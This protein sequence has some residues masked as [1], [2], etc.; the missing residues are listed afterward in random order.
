MNISFLGAAHEVTGS[1]HCLKACGKT[2]LIDFGMRQGED[3]ND[4]EEL[5]LPISPTKVD[6]VLL[7]HAHIDHSGYLPLLTKY[8]FKG[9]IYATGATTDLCNIMLRDSAHIQEFETEW[10]NRKGKRAGRP[11][12]EPIYDMQDAEEVL[13]HFVPCEYDKTVNICDGIDVTF[14][15]AGHLLGSAS[16]SVEINE[17][18]LERTVVF[19]GDIGNLNQPII[20]D[21]TYIKSADF[22]VMESTYGDKNHEPIEGNYVDNLTEIIESTF[23]RGGNVIIPS[24]AVGRTQELLYFLRKIK[25]RGLVKTN[26]D[27]KVYVDSPLAVEATQVFNQ[28]IAGYFDEEAMALV[29]AGINPLSFN[30]LI[31][32]VTS[33]ESKAINFDTDCKVVISAS[34][35]CEAGRIKHHLKH[36][37]WR[38][39]CTILFVGYQAVGTLGRS[40]YDGAKTVKIFGEEIDVEAQILTMKQMSGHADQSG[41]LK[42]INSYSP[43]PKG[44]YVVHGDAK[45]SEDF[46]GM[47]RHNFGLNAVAPNKNSIYDLATGECIDFG[48]EYKPHSSKVKLKSKGSPV[49]TRL[50]SMVDRLVKIA[51]GYKERPNKDI[52]KFADQVKALCDKWD[53]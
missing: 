15:D 18:G 7:T 30:G 17:D 39:E 46:S 48:D 38:P 16:I 37:L 24:F 47:L 45:V 2:I 28:N 10:K 22:V 6:Y 1:C 13:T 42:W 11:E 33:D 29:N 5:S 20:E 26:P 25:E 44:V 40:I 8:G 9:Q 49:F 36:N 41:L 27:F 12:V 43:K 51:E 31:T 23:K 3:K 21:P 4:D 34:G 53:D 35:M 14:R 32:S 50:L 19:S 52:A